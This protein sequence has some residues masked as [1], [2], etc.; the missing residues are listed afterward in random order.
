MI[1]QADFTAPAAVS[2]GLPNHQTGRTPVQGNH[3]HAQR[4]RRRRDRRQS[5]RNS[6]RPDA[7]RS[8]CACPRPNED[9][10]ATTF[11]LEDFVP[12]QI[13]VAVKTDQERFAAKETIKAEIFAEH[14][15]GAPA[16]GLKA[17]VKCIYSP[18]SFAPKQ[19]TD[20]QFGRRD[21]KPLLAR[22]EAPIIH[23]ETPGH[24][25]PGAR[26]R[27]QGRPP[28]SE[29]TCPANA[30]GP[31]RAQVQASVFE[32]SGRSVTATKTAIIDPY[33][34]YIGMKRFESGWLKSGESPQAVGRRRAPDG[35]PFKPVKPLAVRLSRIDWNYSYKSS[36]GR[37]LRLSKP[38]G[39]HAHAGGPARPVVRQRRICVHPD[40]LWPDSNSPSSIRRS[41]TA[42]SFSFYTSDYEQSWTTTE[43]ERPDSLTLKLD[44]PEYRIGENAR[45]TIQ[46][47]FRGHGAADDRVRQGAAEPGDPVGKKH[48]GGGCGGQGYLRA[49]RALHGL[50]HPPGGG[51][52]GVEGTPRVR[53]RA[54]QSFARPS[55]GSHVALETPQTILP[56][57]KLRTTVRLTDDAGQPVD[58]E[59]TLM[60]VDEAICM[61]TS[62]KIAVAARLVL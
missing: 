55:T 59:V 10:G 38:P 31:V 60:A 30:P 45:L 40:R 11:L 52:S 5:C 36:S 61:L 35:E 9:L 3:R 27:R 21:G 29:P 12:P 50:G 25:R 6:C 13:R 1:R 8:A 33:P 47:P 51:G 46:A 16:A 43:R 49:E 53:L 62:F 15:F 34:F 28:K 26:C 56:Q 14:L 4:L 57:S 23:H 48:R 44:K 32:Q 20:Y 22:T 37:R 2:G 18:V 42:S 24:R 7:T 41:G 54:A 19:W 17:N 58:G 39:G